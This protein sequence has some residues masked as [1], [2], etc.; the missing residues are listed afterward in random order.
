MDVYFPPGR[1]PFPGVL[2]IHGG[3]WVLGHVGGFGPEAQYLAR[4]GFVAFD[5]GYRLAPGF[6]YPSQVQDVRAAVRF[7]RA[8][9]SKYSVLPEELGALGGSAGG[10][11]AAMLGVLGHGS[12]DRGSRVNAVVTWSG[13]MDFIEPGA[14]SFTRRSY[15]AEYLGCTLQQCPKRYRDASPISH[16]DSTDAPMMIVNSSKELVPFAPALSMFEALQRAGVPSK[17]VELTGSMH[18]ISYENVD[19]VSLGGEPVIQASAVWLKEYIGAQPTPTP[20]GTLKPATPLFS[21]RAW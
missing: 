10:Q 14:Q 11:L 8:H 9:A 3:G 15:V 2:V 20:L 6:T 5:V 17:L 12:R 19:L 1:G 13:P 7:I 4:Q 18:S 21:A 16:V